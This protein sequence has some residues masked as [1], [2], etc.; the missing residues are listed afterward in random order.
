MHCLL[1][2][3][4]R[5]RGAIDSTIAQEQ[6]RQRH[7][8]ASPSRSNSNARGADSRAISPAKRVSRQG[9]RDQQDGDPP[10]KGPDPADFES[11]FA[12]DDDDLTRSGTPKPQSNQNGNTKTM[13]ETAPRQS[14]SETNEKSTAAGDFGALSILPTDVREK[15]R[16]LEKYESRY[17]GMFGNAN[18]TRRLLKAPRAA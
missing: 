1:T 10:A 13:Q 11:E 17:H 9:T 2:V 5:I 3:S 6:A 16:K 4:Q 8:Q 7:A 14:S 12:I 15:L 18:R